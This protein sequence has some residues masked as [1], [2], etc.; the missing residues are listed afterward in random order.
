VRSLHRRVSK[1]ESRCDESREVARI[2]GIIRRA[3][4]EKLY[5][6][7]ESGQLARMAARLS[8]REFDQLITELKAMLN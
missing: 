1:I 7:N 8:H 2:V 6:L 3:S 4:N 5:W